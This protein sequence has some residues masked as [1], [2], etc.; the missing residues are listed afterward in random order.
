M[1]K[2]IIRT[3][4]APSSPLY[5][6]GV[7]VGSTIYVSGQAGMDPATKQMAGPTVQDQTRQAIRN[8]EAVL[9]AGG[10]SLRDVVSVTVLLANPSDWNGLNEAYAK[11]FPTDPPTRAVTRLG[12]ELP[13]VLVSVTMIAQIEG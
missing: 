12:P 6:Q 13:G 3:E 10:A 8:C 5:S 11:A 4:K 7:K 9:E 2:Q 1:T